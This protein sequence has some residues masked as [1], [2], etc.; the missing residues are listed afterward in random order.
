MKWFGESWR[1]PICAPE[2]EVKTPVGERCL[3]CKE[4][5]EAG[6]QGLMMPFCTVIDAEPVSRQ[7]A[8]HIECFLDDVL[9]HGPDCK[10]CRGLELE[11][12]SS[13]CLYKTDNLE[14]SCDMGRRMERLLDPTL[15]LAEA[16]T[17]AKEVGVERD[18]LLDLMRHRRTRK[19]AHERRSRR[20]AEA[21]ESGVV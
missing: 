3:L 14:C 6:D 12:H 5:I 19:D 8:E 10:R 18:Y 1:A 17:I 7:I 15:T 4:H 20:K 9:P 16:E 21:R 11:T 2:N 13:S